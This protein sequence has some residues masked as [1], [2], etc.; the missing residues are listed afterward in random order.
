MSRTLGQPASIIVTESIDT[1]LTNTQLTLGVAFWLIVPTLAQ[2][3]PPSGFLSRVPTTNGSVPW[4][5]LGATAQEVAMLATGQ[6]LEVFTFLTF[7]LAFF[8]DAM[9]LTTLNTALTNLQARVTAAV[10]PSAID[11]VAANGSRA[12][13][14]IAAGSNGLSLP[15]ATISVASTA[16]MATAGPAIVQT[17]AGPQYVLYTGISGNTLT[18]C[19]GGTGAMATGGTVDAWSFT[20]G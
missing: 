7:P 6:Y 19:T 5:T 2:V 8:T 11:Y 4:N 12:S 3:P 9:A 20:P 10:P 18:G 15:Q 1:Q 13:S 17:A 16:G 14:T